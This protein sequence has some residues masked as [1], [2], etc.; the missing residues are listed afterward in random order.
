MSDKPL[1]TLT[2]HERLFGVA[3]ELIESA[4]AMERRGDTDSL[5]D[6]SA[7]C[8]TAVFLACA[9]LEACTNALASLHYSHPRGSNDAKAAGWPSTGR[10][11]WYG[12]SM[13]HKWQDMARLVPR[14]CSSRVLS[15]LRNDFAKV[16]WRAFPRDGWHGWLTKLSRMRDETIV[17]FK[18]SLSSPDIDKAYQSLDTCIAMCCILFAERRVDALRKGYEAKHKAVIK[19]VAR[20]SP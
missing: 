20:P 9:A 17:H 1:Y 15:A 4:R 19:G 12:K 11:R 16:G 8:A 7:R 3:R 14:G 13:S 5:A 2:I 10:Q 6:A 18:G